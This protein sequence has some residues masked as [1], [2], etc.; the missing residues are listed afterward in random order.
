MRLAIH[1]RDQKKKKTFSANG[2]GQTQLLHVEEN[3]ILISHPSQKSTL[4]K[5]KTSPYVLILLILVKEKVGLI[6][7]ITGPQ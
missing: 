7:T 2:T 4:N 3:E 5:S 6:S 1:V